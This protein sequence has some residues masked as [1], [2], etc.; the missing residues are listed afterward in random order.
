MS[1]LPPPGWYTDPEDPAQHRYWDGS[2]WT[3][4]QSPGRSA[5]SGHRGISGLLTGTGRLFA[6]NWRPFVVIYTLAAVVAFGGEQ[7]VRVG[8]DTVFGDTLTAPLDELQTPDPESEDAGPVHEDPWYEVLLTLDPDSGNAGPALEDRRDGV[9]ERWNY[10]WDRV[11][12]LSPS[13]VGGGVLL[14]AIGGLAAG[15]VTIVQF[16]ALGHLVMRLLAHPPA[17][18]ATALL[19]GLRRVLRIVGV[20]LML[21]LMLTT[22]CMAAPLVVGVVVGVLAVASVPLGAEALVLLVLAAAAALAL[23]APLALLTLM[24]AAVGPAE[25][26]MLYARSL[27]R[28]SYGA[29][30][31]RTVLLLALFAIA[32]SVV[33]LVAA[34]AGLLAAPLE[35]V[36]LYALSVLP[37]TLIL[38]ALFI[39]Y[40]DLGGE[41]AEVAEEAASPAD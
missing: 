16:A 25:P 36:T 22:A 4:H 39:L 17:T 1:D 19:A 18:A 40:H 8:F 30:L 13:A 11:G 12:S 23:A 6:A 27:L 9:P 5:G 24:T 35:T 34:L 10:V 21:L 26:S 37:E 28:G 15:V 29:T 38:I 2:Q 31:G 33:V 14:M 3:D 20:G 7:L 41:H 32:A